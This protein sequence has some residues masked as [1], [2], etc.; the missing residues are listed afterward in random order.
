MF[1]ALLYKSTISIDLPHISSV[2][3]RLLYNF[4]LFIH[5]QYMWHIVKNKLYITCTFTSKKIRKIGKNNT[6][7]LLISSSGSALVLIGW[8]V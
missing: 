1:H 6:N 4:F 2:Y 7:L 8:L 3:Y 5:F